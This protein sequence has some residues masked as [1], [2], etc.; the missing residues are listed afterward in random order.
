MHS[1]RYSMPMEDAT[2]MLELS[3][4]PTEFKRELREWLRREVPENWQQKLTGVSEADYVEFQKAWF[5]KLSSIGLTTAHWPTSWGGASLPLEL[6]A[7]V[8]RELALARAPGLALFTISLYHVPAT[9]SSAGSAEQRERYLEDVR[10]GAI[11]CQG[12]SEPGAGSD[13]A[14]LQTRAVKTKQGYVVN[15]QKVWSSM[16]PYAS[17]CLLLARTD[18]DA[19]KHRGISYF[20][21]DM[22]SPGVTVRPIRQIDGY[23]EFAEIYLDDVHVPAENLIGNEGEGWKI[24]QA[25][26]SAER[27]LFLF[28]LIER[29]RLAMQDYLDREVDR[30]APWINDDGHQREFSTLW[31]RMEGVRGMVE[32]LM[33]EHDAEYADVRLSPAYAKLEFSEFIQQLG[34]FQTRVAGLSGQI[35]SPGRINGG[36]FTGNAMFDYLSTWRQTISGGTNEIMRNIIAETGLDMPRS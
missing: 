15:G 4:N 9:L 12:F 20:I 25:T 31:G 30:G 29:Q 21:M 6:Q 11:W 8:S 18:P 23:S 32:A 19:S 27:G 17:H 13:L 5:Q 3:R 36:D 35:Y 2:I 33:H 34:A 24:A 16:S 1:V 10:N 14:S 28:E 22:D 7:L 26:L